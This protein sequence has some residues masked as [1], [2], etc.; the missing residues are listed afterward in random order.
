MQTPIPATAAAKRKKEKKKGM[1]V[2][3]VSLL[4]VAAAALLLACVCAAAAAE[5]DAACKYAVDLRVTSGHRR[6]SAVVWV[7][8]EVHGE[9]PLPRG[10]TVLELDVCGGAVRRV[11]VDDV[12]FDVAASAR[13][14]AHPPLSVVNSAFPAGVRM[15]RGGVLE[16]RLDQCRFDG[17]DNA[18]FFERREPFSLGS[19]LRSPAVMMALPMVLMAAMPLLYNKQDMA[20]I[21]NY[22]VDTSGAPFFDGAQQKFDCLPQF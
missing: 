21:L 13:G 10:E 16:V 18:R 20:D 5:E 9:V 15:T 2:R 12:V 1:A 8:G 4:R 19:L 22:P 3:D 11:R 14:G 6:G 17:G 7:D